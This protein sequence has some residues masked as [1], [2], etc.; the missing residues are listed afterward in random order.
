MRSADEPNTPV[1]ARATL[2]DPQS[3]VVLWMNESVSE[4]RSNLDSDTTLSGV[5]I[6]QAVPM[7]E[8]L[9]VPEAL[10]VVADTGVAQHL[11]TEL[12]STARGSVEIAVSIYR[13][14][15]GKLL[16]LTENAWHAEH[17]KPGGS[18][19]RSSGRRAR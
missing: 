6:E 8:A 19:P 16:V 15:D 11:R 9:G 12:I 3:M 5:S 13:L 10:R 1:K 7:A 4:A 18:V 2:I 14:P 17:R